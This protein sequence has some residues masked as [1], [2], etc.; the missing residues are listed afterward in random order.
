MGFR[1]TYLYNEEDDDILDKRIDILKKSLQSI[2][3]IIKNEGDQFLIIGSLYDSTTI[4]T[5]QKKMF[6]I[7]IIDQVVRNKDISYVDN[8]SNFWKFSIY[9]FYIAKN[10]YYLKRYRE[11]LDA[12]EKVFNIYPNVPTVISNKGVVF[13]DLGE[14][15]KAIECFDQVIDEID[16]QYVDAWFNKGVVLSMLRKNEEAINCYQKITKDL[17]PNH[18]KAYLNIGLIYHKLGNYDKAIE[19]YNQLLKIEPKYYEAL[20][21]KGLSLYKQNKYQEAITNYNECL[22]IKPDHYNTIN[23]IGLAYHKSG[24]YDKAIKSYTKAIKIQK[25]YNLPQDADLLYNRACSKAENKM[26][27]DSILDLTSAIQIGKIK[28]IE[29]A[30]NEKSFENLQT[31]EKFKKLFNNNEE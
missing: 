19:N 3:T 4:D 18:I 26:I 7:D 9:N 2:M 31:N 14:K 5:E 13:A 6:P 30:K 10:Y 12:I 24:D 27:D 20:Y 11:S 28:Y 15:E 21:N 16:D 17:D 29:L 1:I 22:K 8:L 23:N 25:K